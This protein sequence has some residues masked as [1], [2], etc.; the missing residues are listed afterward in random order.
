MSANRKLLSGAFGG[1][2]FTGLSMAISFL[3]MRVLLRHM[4]L[5]MAGVWLIFANL[6]SYALFLDIGL[7]PTLGREVSFAV[8]NPNLSDDERAVRISSLIRSCTVI[9]AGL[10]SLVL[11]LGGVLGWR[12]L[13]SIAP[14]GIWANT[15][16][17]WAIYI[18][19]TALNLVGQGWFAGIYGL[20]Q[21]FRE[22]TVR[23]VSTL[24]GFVFFLIALSTSTGLVGLAVAY[25]LQ[26]I[27]SITLARISL[28]RLTPS[29]KS[30]SWF[31]FSIVRGM[32]GPSLKYALTML[33]GILILQTDNI[34][35]ASILG[36]S[37]VPDYQAVAKMVTAL[38]SVSMMLV[39]TSMPL[40]SQAHAS[41]DTAAIVKYLS[42]NV[43]ITLGTIVIFG[44][45]LACFS[46]RV[47][48]VWLGD[49]HFVGFPV[50]WVLLTVMLL[51]A[52]HQAMA[53]ATMSTGRIAFVAPALIAG[54]LNIV[55]SVVLA[56][57]YGLL[58]VVLG[59]MAAQVITNNWYA[60]MY[61]LRYFNLKFANHV[62]TVV[63]PTAC[64]VAVVLSVGFMSRSLT[65]HLPNII[66]DAIGGIAIV[67]AGAICFNF[68]MVTPSERGT[69][70]KKLLQMGL[71]WTASSQTDVLQ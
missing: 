58:G 61:T 67:I 46:D 6:G 17:A 7:T 45:F 12:Y 65:S 32:I 63:L 70:H 56:R 20:G 18:V 37:A 35:I 39:M 34:V 41:S 33:G 64:L 13:H 3:Q 25:L 9:V 10:S 16:L 27:V 66:S 68:V 19:A 38:M 40:I 29:V 57:R 48:A 42:R 49:G 1:V 52:H 62:R 55:F 28:S 26:V 59:T 24:I 22:K 36:P 4:S 21:V 14:S 15:R 47:I 51:E 60:P 50:V 69:L 30:T 53:A 54:V 23:S 71:R 5:E 2:V 8:G 44:S 43:R 31:D 11:L